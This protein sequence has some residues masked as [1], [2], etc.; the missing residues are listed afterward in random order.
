[1]LKFHKITILGTDIANVT[2][3]EVLS[4]IS[5]SISS[6]QKNMMFFVNAHNLTQAY[7]NLQYRDILGKTNFI[8]G[9]GIGVYLAGKVTRQKVLDNVNGTDVFPLICELCEKERYAVYFLGSE[10]GIV[11]K[12]VK[13][14]KL[15]Y[16]MLLVAGASHGYFDHESGS[17]DIINEINRTGTKI[18]FVG[19]GT[20]KQEEWIYENISLLK[21]NIAIGVGG[22]FDFYSGSK[23]RAPKWVRIVGLEWLFRLS[24]E[25]GRLWRRYLIGIPHFIFYVLKQRYYK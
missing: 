20:P 22:L 9:D 3:H 15:K 14:L 17:K 12:M 1:M 4:H 11:E 8:Y 13:K 10:P 7:Y 19:L 25:P 24:Q 6:S 16:P 18:L 21:C 23:I 5:E 2:R